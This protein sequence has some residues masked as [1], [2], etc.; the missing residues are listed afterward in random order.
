MITSDNHKTDD[1][2]SI[3]AENP[4][5]ENSSE[6]LED[7]SDIED[8]ENSN[9]PL[10]D[11]QQR[12]S[13]RIINPVLPKT[14]DVIQTPNG[15]TVYLVGTAHFSVESQND[16]SKVIQQTVPDVV[17]VELCRSRLGIVSYDESALLEKA[18]KMNFSNIKSIIKEE[19]LYHGIVNMLMYSMSAQ[20]TKQLGMAPGGEFR[21]AFKECSQIPGCRLVLGDRPI[22]ITMKRA[23]ASLSLWQRIKFVWAIITCNE[24][25]TKETVEQFKDKDLV[26]QFL[27]EMAGDFPG[28][29]R[30]F[31]TER[32]IYL[33]HTI[34]SITQQPF[35]RNLLDHLPKVVVAIIGIGHVQGIKEHWE[36]DHNI[37]HILEVPPPNKSW[38]RIKLTIKI[39]MAIFIA[40]STYKILSRYI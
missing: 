30:V 25:I 39:S 23:V 13:T 8:T 18:Q 12:E 26:E 10:Y 1:I 40:W 14:V 31:V 24:T 34:K 11:L 20:I 35:D 22:D 29:K 38:T 27:H 17:I 15:C 33:S 16:V 5:I 4:E 21:T 7:H 19:G 9:G 3:P 2:D 37:S 32:D 28:L 6:G 36:E